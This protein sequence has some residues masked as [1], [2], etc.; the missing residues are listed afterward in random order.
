MSFNESPSLKEYQDGI[1]NKPVDPSKRRRTTRVILIILASFSLLLFSK[2]LYDSG[3]MNVILGKGAVSGRV[4]DQK[5]S[6]LAGQAFILGSEN[7]VTI[8]PDGNFLIEGVPSGFNSLVIA[9]N[10]AAEEYPVNIVPGEITELNEIKF[11]VVTQ[12][13]DQE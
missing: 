5:G 3:S 4:M 11:L 2:N 1:P 9:H 10:G 13:P 8:D 12:I 6:P 7:E